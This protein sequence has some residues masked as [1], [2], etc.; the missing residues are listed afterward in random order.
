MLLRDLLSRY[1]MILLLILILLK[2]L[3][4]LHLI[5]TLIR[6]VI[7]RVSSRR[8]VRLQAGA[9]LADHGQL[10]IWHHQIVLLLLLLLIQLLRL[11]MTVV[12]NVHLGRRDEIVSRGLR[13]I[14][15]WDRNRR[16]LHILVR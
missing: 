6:L 9:L 12:L 10:R 11:R 5:I 7:C 4:I 2:L 8:I 14:L 3:N 13:I 16:L 15:W 1:L